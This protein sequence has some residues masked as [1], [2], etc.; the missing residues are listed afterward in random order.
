[1]LTNVPGPPNQLYFAGAQIV[2]GFGIGPLVP[3]VG[4]FHTASSSVMNKRGKINFSFWACRD[5][6]PNPDFYKQCIEET[7]TEL[8]AATL[9]PKPGTKAKSGARA[10]PKARVRT[11]AKPKAKAKA[12]A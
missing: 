9:S 1:M 10:K 2:E 8:K 11:R 6:L 5:M 12:K 3:G 4:L 7:Y